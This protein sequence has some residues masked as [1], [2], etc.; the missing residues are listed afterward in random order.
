MAQKSRSELQELFKKGAKPSQQDFADFI[1]ST[2]N[3][4]DDG[5]EKPFG[6]DTPLKITAQ[7]DNEKLLEFLDK[8]GGSS[9]SIS[10][11]PGENKLG[12]NISNSGGSKLFIESS[13]GNVGIGTTSPGNH[14]LNV[15]GDQYLSGNLTVNG[16]ISGQIDAA[17]ISGVLTVEK[18]PKLSADKITS[19]TIDGNLTLVDGSLKAQSLEITTKLIQVKKIDLK[20]S[21]NH[22]TGYST[23]DWVC[24]I[25]GFQ[26][27]AGDIDEGSENKP[28]IYVYTY[29]QDT[30]WY[31]RADFLSH[32]EHETWTVWIIAIRKAIAEESQ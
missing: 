11:K 8:N 23:N 29:Q 27:S 20:G 32:D 22:D 14:K 1:E 21:P 2:L 7:G 3:V 26:T 16:T 12:L 15:Q 17:N 25:F 28:I 13:S 18:I 19:G 5:I 30:K 4:K 10:Q 9:W 24:G 31:V 6:A